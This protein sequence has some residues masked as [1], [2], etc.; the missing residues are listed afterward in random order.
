[1]FLSAFWLHCFRGWL[2]A[3]PWSKISYSL[4]C[5]RFETELFAFKYPCLNYPA[6]AADVLSEEQALVDQCL[7]GDESAYYAFV[8]QFQSLVFGVCLRMLGDRQEA[9]D[10]AQE[11]FVR[12]LRNLGQWDRQRPLRPW[13]LTITANRCRTYLHLRGRRPIASESV[14]EVVDPRADEDDAHELR[15]EIRIALEQLR[16]DY[17]RVFLLFHEQG[18]SY[19]EMSEATGKP[20]GTIKTWLHRA[21]NEML[22][23]LRQKGLATEVRHDAK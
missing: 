1:M 7:A 6:L 5:R 3:G 12:A 21:R 11:V 23:M 22:E 8:E 16:P 17:R 20:I 18:L 15:S 14:A 10:A 19:E 9:E 4:Y 2:I 13:L